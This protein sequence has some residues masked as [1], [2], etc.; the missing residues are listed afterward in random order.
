MN[1]F[2]KLIGIVLS[3]T[4]MTLISGCGGGGDTT[5][6]TATT[7][8]YSSTG[9]LSLSMTDAPP[10]LE[11]EVTEVN[12]AVIGIEYNY[13]GNWTAAEGF[14]PQTFNLLDLQNGK[15]LHLGDL[16]LPAG[17]YSEIR[18]ILAAP[19]KESEVKA[20]PDCN[21]TFADGSS[22][23]LFVP[24]GA[25]S[26]YKGKGE[27]EITADAKIA[28]TAD[29]DVHKAIVVAGKSGKYLLKPTIR[30]VV[31][32]LSGMIN[33]T[34]V[35]VADYNTTAN[36]ADNNTTDNNTTVAEA[37][38]NT[39]SNSLVVYTYD[40]GAYSTDEEIPNGELILF[41]N[42]VSSSDVNMSDGNFTLAFLE[43]GMYTLVTALYIDNVFSEVVDI[44]DNVEVFKGKTTLVDINTSDTL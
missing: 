19:T 37:D 10:K 1:I 26:G 40:N 28:V 9:T 5:T 35:D 23:P 8:S 18:F 29:F 41:E 25:E 11:K 24:S 33:G 44:E 7:P 31:T 21:I 30:L 2:H 4:L 42:A 27:F 13:E 39:T 15:S 32:E 17:H 22:V 36:G 14:I 16:I 3:L 6:A 20:N 43:E 38:Q 12:I 34:V